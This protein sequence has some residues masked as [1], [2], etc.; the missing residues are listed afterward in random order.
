VFPYQIIFSGIA[1]LFSTFFSMQYITL[2]FSENQRFSSLFLL[3]FNKITGFYMVFGAKIT[4]HTK[5]FSDIPGAVAI[6]LHLNETIKCVFGCDYFEPVLGLGMFGKIIF[7]YFTTGLSM[8]LKP[9][10]KPFCL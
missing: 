10:F 1:G 7:R 2:C 8:T 5:G 9:Y 6:P 4:L 3:T